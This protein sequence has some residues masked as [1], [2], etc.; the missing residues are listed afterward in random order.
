MA[1]PQLDLRAF[2]SKSSPKPVFEEEPG[3]RPMRVL[4]DV[5][6]FRE[7]LSLRLRFLC[8]LAQSMHIELAVLEASGDQADAVPDGI[9]RLTIREPDLE[10][11]YVPVLVGYPGHAGYI[12]IPRYK[13]WKRL[14][15]S[16]LL[17][18]PRPAEKKLAEVLR[19]RA[20]LVW[21]ADVFVT[22][23]DLLLKCTVTWIREA[24]PMPLADALALVGLF[25]R[26]RGEY[27]VAP[28]DGLPTGFPRGWSYMYTARA[29]LPAGF[30]FY[31]AVLSTST[32]SRPPGT[33]ERLAETV[34][35]R[36]ARALTARDHMMANVQQRHEH[37]ANFDLLYHLDALLVQFVGAFDALARIADQAARLNSKPLHIGW[38]S[39]NWR[40]A[41]RDAKTAPALI[42]VLGGDKP[43][44]N[45]IELLGTL[46]NNIHGDVLRTPEPTK[47][48]A[49]Y[50]FALSL[51]E[52]DRQKISQAVARLGGPTA[53]RLTT[54]PDGAMHADI[55]TFVER[56]T[57]KSLETIDTLMKLTPVEALAGYDAAKVTD[58]PPA[59]DPIVGARI[60]EALRMSF[61]LA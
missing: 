25:L 30:R 61:G 31:S 17:Q 7:P 40:E 23:W 36:V 16:E 45:V 6:L 1:I 5:R 12:V 55:V 29:V 32:G 50:R 57:N 33:A 8:Q 42:A 10:N 3:G 27:A 52:Q 14:A 11:D 60:A 4:V 51:P 54:A 13:Q 48:D 44:R 2:R 19:A 49:P 35:T 20:A 37:S 43:E 22:E 46:R 41:L 53:W 15:N 28:V 21:P 58:A 9:L 18:F 47:D 24:N 56:L 38:H 34:F 26:R 39:E 59:D